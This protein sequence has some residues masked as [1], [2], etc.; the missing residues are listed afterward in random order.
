MLGELD[1]KMQIYII[2]H[3]KTDWNKQSRFQG[4]IDIPLNEEGRNSAKTLGEKLKNVDFDLIYSSPLSRA[5]ETASL[6]RG[7]RNIKIIKNELLTEVSFGEFEGITFDDFMNTD[8]PRKFYFTE[9]EKYVPPKGGE[10]IES[11]LERTKKFLETELLPLYEKSPSC[12]I[13]IVAHGAILTSL[14]TNLE[15]RPKSQYWG[16]GLKKNCEET[17]YTYNGKVWKNDN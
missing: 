10:T 2:R 4:K 1:V 13:M 16:T 15:N 5:Y 7:E 12:R 11:S 17:I 6:I 9:P 8:E 14:M 3:G